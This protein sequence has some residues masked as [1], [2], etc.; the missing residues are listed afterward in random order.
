MTLFICITLCKPD[1]WENISY[2][3]L[4][5]CWN[6]SEWLFRTSLCHLCATLVIIPQCNRVGDFYIM[7]YPNLDQ[8]KN[9][10]VCRIWRINFQCGDILHTKFDTPIFKRRLFWFNMQTLNWRRAP[11][12]SRN[13]WRWTGYYD[14]SQLE[15]FKFTTL[16]SKEEKYHNSIVA[17]KRICFSFDQNVKKYA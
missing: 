8:I 1:Q 7:S 6:Y 15:I 11:S 4:C 13:P 12:E 9:K 3:F 5:N 17:E 2:V 14:I 10:V 16:N